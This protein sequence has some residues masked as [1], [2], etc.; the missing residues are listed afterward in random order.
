MDVD[1]I[2]L[3]ARSALGKKTRYDLGGGMPDRAAAAWPDGA[4]TDCSGFVAWCLRFR[5]KVDHPLYKKINGGWFETTAVHADGLAT[6]G[7]FTKLLKP[8]P[9]AIVVYPDYVDAAGRHREGH[10]GIVTQVKPNG[11]GVAA[12]QSVI[13]CSAGAWKTKKDAV[14]ETAPT[15]W[16]ARQDAIVVWMDGI[17]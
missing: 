3:R 15:A 10:I 14:Q 9:G 12:V 7:F 11:I 16:T 17:I 6:T 8:T 4:A 5:R 1:T 13:H 2:L